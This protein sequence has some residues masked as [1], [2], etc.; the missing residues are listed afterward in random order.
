MKK[1]TGIDTV[2]EEGRILLIAFQKDFLSTVY[3]IK[4]HYQSLF[5]R[6][7]ELAPFRWYNSY[8]GWSY[9]W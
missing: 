8:I 4:W 2:D 1:F 3:I 6:H 5:I 7:E 9:D